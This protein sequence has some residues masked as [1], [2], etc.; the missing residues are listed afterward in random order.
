[1]QMSGL[2]VPTTR[3]AASS[4]TISHTHVF[5]AQ[6]NQGTAA[7]AADGRGERGDDHDHARFFGELPYKSR[8]SN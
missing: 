8:S 3:Q 4:S 7:E 6:E 5:A 2:T 1:M